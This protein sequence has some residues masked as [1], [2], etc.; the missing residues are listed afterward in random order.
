MN[1]LQKN[2]LNV[3]IDF[4]EFAKKNG[5]KYS[6]AWG[7]LLGAVR[8]KGFI[9]WDDDVD[10]SMD[11]VNFNKLKRVCEK[12]GLPEHLVFRGPFKGCRVSKIRDIRGSVVDKNGKKGYF[13]DIFP[14]RKYTSL[15]VRILSFFAYGLKIRDY[16]KKI[17]NK[18]LRA[19]YSVLSLIPYYLF[20]VN[21]AI[22]VWKKESL[23][24]TYVGQ[25][26][27]TNPVCFFCADNFFDTIEGEFEGN[28]FP[29]PMD[30]DK[31]LKQAYGDYMIPINENNQHY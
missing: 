6:L 5:I 15:E 9:P 8:H 28:S 29:I 19:L 27:S 10:V 4:D 11:L 1:D 16:R 20:I 3:L 18:A 17:N 30:W 12:G 24:G 22:F 2:L 26:P 21:R 23:N 25:D 14:F 7:T 31:V 13:I